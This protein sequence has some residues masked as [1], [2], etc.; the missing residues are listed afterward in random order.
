MP[1]LVPGYIVYHVEHFAWF[2][3][4]TPFADSLQCHS[5]ILKFERHSYSFQS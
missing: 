3:M 1:C 2:I 5:P 4:D